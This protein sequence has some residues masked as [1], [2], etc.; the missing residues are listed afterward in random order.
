[1]RLQCVCSVKVYMNHTV[2]TH[3]Y[4]DGHIHVKNNTLFKG[5]LAAE[6]VALLPVLESGNFYLFLWDDRPNTVNMMSCLH[7]SIVTTVQ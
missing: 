1:M 6:R 3:H 4:T 2:Y 7:V 5:L